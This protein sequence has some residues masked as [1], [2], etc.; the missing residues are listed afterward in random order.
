[1]EEVKI[2]ENFK[3]LIGLPKRASS[4]LFY[5]SSGDTVS[6]VIEYFRESLNLSVGDL[7]A[8]KPED[9]EGKKNI[10]SIKQIRE[11][12]HFINLTP[13]GE[14]KVAAIIG[15]ENMNRESA[16]A[17]LKTLEEPPKSAVIILFA[18]RDTLLPTIK[19]RCKIIK[20]RGAGA[21]VQSYDEE[22][23]KQISGSFKDASDTI[24]KVVKEDGIEIF[25]NSLEEYARNILH[26][27]K[28]PRSAKF[29]KEIE[30][31]RSDIGKNAN[32]KL[33][34]E[35]LILKNREIIKGN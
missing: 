29:L 25:L 12:I 2:E 9:S 14:A 22:V 10:I 34:L 11:L 16:N 3:R 28:S 30:K 7:S 23:V 35:S 8:I 21:S 13:S 33:T 17:F 27:E 1:M 18:F 5:V 24:D 20:M 32:S 4:Y 26:K 15:A 31:A 19:S 6:Q